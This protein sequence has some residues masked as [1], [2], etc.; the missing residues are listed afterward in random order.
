MAAASA[1]LRRFKP[2]IAAAVL[3]AAVATVP[4]PA[5]AGD[6]ADMAAEAEALLEAG[7]PT[8][9]FDAMD[10]AVDAFWRAAPLI[11]EDARFEVDGEAAGAAAFAPGEGVGILVQ[12]LGYGFDTAGG[13][14]RIALATDIE[15]R[16]PGGLILARSDDLGRLEWSGPG[17][18]RA[19][20][21]RVNIDMPELKAGDYELG[22]GQDRQRDAAVRD[23]GVVTVRRNLTTLRRFE[24]G[25]AGPQADLRAHQ[26]HSR[27]TRL[28]KFTNERIYS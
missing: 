23:R 27:P 10:A 21:G 4:A 3:S 17:K 12:P 2:A 1:I 8:T 13:G 15:I 9:A 5:L 18:N 26:R 6:V 20:A 22:H 16:T 19:F 24:R 11:I 14:F 28:R 7:E 25:S